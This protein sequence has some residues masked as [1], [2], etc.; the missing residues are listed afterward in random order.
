MQAFEDFVNAKLPPVLQKIESG[1]KAAVETVKKT[2]QRIADAALA[3]LKKALA[4][5]TSALEAM[6]PKVQVSTISILH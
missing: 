1:F 6:P 2:V 4:A 3:V 5:L